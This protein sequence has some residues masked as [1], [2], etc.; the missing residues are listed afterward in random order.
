M[1]LQHRFIKDALTDLLLEVTTS[2]I[3]EVCEETLLQARLA[4]YGRENDIDHQEDADDDEG[5]DE[6]KSS[7][8]SSQPAVAGVLGEFCIFCYKNHHFAA[9]LF[10]RTLFPTNTEQLS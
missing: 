3:N 6:D 9:L 4:A 10:H 2:A 8:H 1:H 5:D 7:V